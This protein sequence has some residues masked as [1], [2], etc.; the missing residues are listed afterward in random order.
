MTA[1]TGCGGSAAVAA[2]YRIRRRFSAARRSALQLTAAG[3]AGPV[4][5]RDLLRAGLVGQECR[6]Q[7]LTG[8]GVEHVDLMLVMRRDTGGGQML[9]GPGLGL[10]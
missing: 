3:C 9:C 7:V 6:A 2:A 4:H 5:L 10:G 1:V 8:A